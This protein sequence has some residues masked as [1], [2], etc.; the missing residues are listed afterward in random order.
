MHAGDR[1]CTVQPL[2]VPEIVT[3]PK[4]IDLSNAPCVGRELA[5]AIGAGARVVIA[6]MSITEFCDSSGIRQLLV[7]NDAAAKRGGELRLVVRSAAVLKVL[8]LIGADK[9]LSIYGTMGDAL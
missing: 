7:A 2:L 8:Q 1:P 3:L 6:D 5:S 9:V 4:E